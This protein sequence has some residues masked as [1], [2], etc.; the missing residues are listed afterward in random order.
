MSFYIIPALLPIFT[1]LVLMTLFRWSPGKVMPL[2]LVMTLVFAGVL[3]RVPA[4]DL[5]VYS[6]LG[7]GKALDIVLIVFSAVLLLNVMKAGGKMQLINQ[8]LSQVSSDRRIQVLI[9]G[10]MSSGFME[11]ASG[12]GAAPALAAPLLYAMGFPA[13]TAVV[14]S[15]ICNTLPVPFGAVGIPAQTAVTTVSNQLELIGTTPQ[16][17]R[18][19]AK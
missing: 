5:A 6:L 19:N 11:G 2:A 16:S 7:C 17:Y 3:W 12:F 18:K 4:P 15:L 1:A 9:I 10:W 13:L 14:V 8:A